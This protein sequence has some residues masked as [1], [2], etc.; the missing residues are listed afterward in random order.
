MNINVAAGAIYSRRNWV[1]NF[2]FKNVA[3]DSSIGVEL[4]PAASFPR[5][6]E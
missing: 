5:L 2:V 1:D 3:N 4:C 6:S